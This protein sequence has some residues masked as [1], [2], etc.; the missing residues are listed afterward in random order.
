MAQRACDSRLPLSPSLYSA[1]AFLLSLI[2]YARLSSGTLLS[3]LMRCWWLF[4]MDSYLVTY[5]LVT[6]TSP[7]GI[8]RRHRGPAPEDA[9]TRTGVTEGD[10]VPGG[11]V[12]ASSSPPISSLPRTVPARLTPPGDGGGRLRERAGGRA[13]VCACS[14]YGSDAIVPVVLA[15]VDVL[16]LLPDL[17]VLLRIGVR[18]VINLHLH[19]LHLTGDEVARDHEQQRDRERIA[20]GAHGVG[21]ARRTERERERE[22]ERAGGDTR[23]N[24]RCR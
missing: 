13:C 10:G 24:G 8:C 7:F 15:H 20:H 14:T 3:S 21:R 1:L 12:R 19:L 23:R 9:D 5:Q 4:L 16:V 17:L 2:M 11:Q 6:F 22:R 18:A